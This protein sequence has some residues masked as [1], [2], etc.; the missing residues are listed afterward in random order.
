MTGRQFLDV[1]HHNTEALLSGFT[2]PH[3]EVPPTTAP[4]PPVPGVSVPPGDTI[5]HFNTVRSIRCIK[6]ITDALSQF[7]IRWGYMR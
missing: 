2:P 4:P 6:Q 7:G 5:P 1:L 3:P